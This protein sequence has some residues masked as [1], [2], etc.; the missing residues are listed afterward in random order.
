MIR[1][2]DLEEGVN[3]C[4]LPLGLEGDVKVDPGAGRWVAQ[5][6]PVDRNGMPGVLYH[7]IIPNFEGRREVGEEHDSG[8][9]EQREPL[10]VK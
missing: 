7:H 4:A 9:G 3:Q 2:A 10:G 5:S 1:V 8:E 6:L